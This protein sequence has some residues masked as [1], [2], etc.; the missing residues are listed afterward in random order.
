MQTFY[1]YVH[2]AMS[3]YSVSIHVKTFLFDI[4]YTDHL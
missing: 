2:N 4:Y 1:V 3:F